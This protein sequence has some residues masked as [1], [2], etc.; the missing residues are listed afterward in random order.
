M[1]ALR[2]AVRSA[3]RSRCQD[4]GGGG[5]T[6]QMPLSAAKPLQT[7]TTA[8]KTRRTIDNPSY[9]VPL[10]IL[11]PANLRNPAAPKCAYDSLLSSNTHGI[12]RNPLLIVPLLLLSSTLATAQPTE[13]VDLNVIHRI[14]EEALGRGS[15]V[16]DHMFY[17]TDVH[18]PRLTDSKGHRMAAEWAV[19]RL[20]EYGLSNVH[21]EKWGPFGK[22]WNLELYSGHMIAPQYQPLIAYPV[23]WTPGTNGVVSGEPILLPTQ[24]QAE[25]DAFKGKL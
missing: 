22:A 7:R 3:T 16:M 6:F 12:M 2:R 1:T 21:L 20:K 14:K 24:T 10:A 11:L 8:H 15:K 23:A 9:T 5:A 25:M 13:K 19:E 4:A 18:G 17:M